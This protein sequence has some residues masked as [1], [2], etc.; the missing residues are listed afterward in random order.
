M[1]AIQMD[2][3]P[4]LAPTTQPPYDVNT[5]YDSTWFVYDGNPVTGTGYSE[6]SAQNESGDRK[7][8]MLIDSTAFYAGDS[9]SYDF[10]VLVARGGTNLENVSALFDLAD[11][12][13]NYFDNEV[14]L[15]GCFTSS[16]ASIIQEKVSDF[17]IFPNPTQSHFLIQFQNMQ[18][19]VVRMYSMT[20]L[21]VH[22]QAVSRGENLVRL[23]TENLNSGIYVVQ[24]GEVIRRV[25]VK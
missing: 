7:T 17:V 2:G 21:L 10:V 15:S 3:A 5:V 19:D 13:Q 23:K 12:V 4:F 9:R 14:L 24:V 1:N 18:P 16:V 22:E 11:S 8:F 25:V 20:G 6:V